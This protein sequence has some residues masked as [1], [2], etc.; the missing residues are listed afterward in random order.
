MTSNVLLLII[1]ITLIGF[2]N[3][4]E[5]FQDAVIAHRD[6]IDEN[7]SA[8]FRGK[9]QHVLLSFSQ[10]PGRVFVMTLRRED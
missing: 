1:L 4:I 7:Q 10:Q 9:D 3:T 8:S 2:E 5:S 6:F